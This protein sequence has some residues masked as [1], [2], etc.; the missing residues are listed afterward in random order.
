MTVDFGKYILQFV[1]N[2]E[3]QQTHL[4]FN[5]G[6]YNVPDEKYEEFYKYYFESMKT[7]DNLYLIEKIANSKFAFFI[8]IDL[9]KQ[10]KINLTDNDVN[11]IIEICNQE[12]NKMFI[13]D[14]NNID[15]NTNYIVSKRND[16]Y[17][18]NYRNLIVDNSI[19]KQL[20]DNIIKN[21]NPELQ[22]SIDTSVYR[23]GLRLLGSKKAIKSKKHEEEI[24]N[25]YDMTN[26]TYIKNTELTFEMFMNTVIRVKQNVELTKMNQEYAQTK[27]N[28]ENKLTKVT[29]K[30]V[31]NNEII[32]EIAIMLNDIKNTNDEIK[33]FNMTIESCR[34]K[35]NKIGMHCYY[36]TV[37]HSHC[38]FKD[39]QHKRDSNPIYIELNMT[40]IYLKCHDSDCIG[41]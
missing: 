21:I 28:G 5:K 37:K 8:D 31:K 40:G 36:I 39:R 4:S 38:P 24:Y 41:S 26:K 22:S 7:N 32:N 35:Q 27:D 10:N 18:I 15:K 33:D 6:K 3:K 23:T 20:C 11:E 17:H 34:T 19:A 2:T 12:I 14:N 25:I 16:K 9:P 13:N 30:G 1:K 29:I